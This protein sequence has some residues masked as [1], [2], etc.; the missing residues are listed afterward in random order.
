MQ[1]VVVKVENQPGAPDGSRSDTTTEEEAAAEAA[2][3]P[4][5]PLPFLSDTLGLLPGVESETFS[6]QFNVD[7]VRFIHYCARRSPNGQ[8]S[9]CCHAV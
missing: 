9:S 3:V 2:G 1:G 7:K 8:S 5:L 4:R 6:V